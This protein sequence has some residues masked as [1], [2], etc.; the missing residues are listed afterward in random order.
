MMGT[1]LVVLA[2][3]FHRLRRHEAAATI[4]DLAINPFTEA[5]L[6]EFNTA[7]TPIPASTHHIIDYLK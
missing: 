2:T 6:P 4:A 7:I 1:P 3:L 5:V